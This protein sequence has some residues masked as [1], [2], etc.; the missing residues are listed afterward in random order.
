[1]NT[2]SFSRRRKF[3]VLSKSGK[4]VPTDFFPVFYS[5]I[6][7]QSPDKRGRLAFPPPFWGLVYGASLG[8]GHLALVICNHFPAL[9]CFSQN[10]GLSGIIRD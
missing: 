9:P 3:F 8:L 4:T 7:P 6:R 10:A 2:L 1:M 5:P